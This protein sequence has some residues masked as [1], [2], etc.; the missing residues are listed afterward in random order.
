MSR[1]GVVLSARLKCG[2]PSNVIPSVRGVLAQRVGKN[3]ASMR[4]L[5]LLGLED[6]ARG[7]AGEE[8]LV[9]FPDVGLGGRREA[10]LHEPVADVR[11][12][13]QLRADPGQVERGNVAR[14]GDQAKGG[15]GT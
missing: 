7:Q 11:L 13:R 3:L 1:I 6:A 4:R 14:V 9:G 8:T 10:G 5:E 12:V 2:T 15:R